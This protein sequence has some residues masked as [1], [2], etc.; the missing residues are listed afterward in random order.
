MN[1][2]GKKSRKVSASPSKLAH[3]RK[4][5]RWLPPAFHLNSP[6]LLGDKSNIH[7]KR[8]R[9]KRVKTCKA[10]ISRA[11]CGRGYGKCT[12][13]DFFNQLYG[14]TGRGRC[15][16]GTSPHSRKKSQSQGRDSLLP[17]AYQSAVLRAWSCDSSVAQYSRSDARS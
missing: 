2:I 15:K 9:G 11:F 16:N 17:K 8:D 12:G 13:E 4:N 7:P 1:R 5:P 10:R 3:S 6:R 14:I